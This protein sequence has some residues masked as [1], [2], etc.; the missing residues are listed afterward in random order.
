MKQNTQPVAMIELT[1]H[2]RNHKWRITTTFCRSPG[3][4]E[5]SKHERQLRAV[6]SNETPRSP[7][8]E[9]QE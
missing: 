2:T 4:R 6:H 1:L 7:D 3:K 5:N 8:S 9:T